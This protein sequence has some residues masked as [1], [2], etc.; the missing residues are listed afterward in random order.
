MDDQIGAEI[1]ATMRLETWHSVN[2]QYRPSGVARR[3][4]ARFETEFGLRH[5]LLTGSGSQAIVAALRGVVPKPS[6]VVAVP[7]GVWEGC[8]R[9]IEWAGFDP[10]SFDVDDQGQPVDR[11]EGVRAVLA[12][13]NLASLVDIGALR[14]AF[15]GA[16]IV[17]DLAHCLGTRRASGHL[18][19]CHGDAAIASFQATKTLSALS[20]GA[21][22]FR[23]ELSFK[24][25]RE[26]I[27]SGQR[28]GNGL[29]EAGCSFLSVA[30]MALLDAQMQRFNEAR[31][32]CA[33]NVARFAAALD[34]NRAWIRADPD[35]LRC[36]TFYSLPIRIRA[37]AEGHTTPDEV[38]SLI[39][40]RTGLVCDRVYEPITKVRSGDGSGHYPH[41]EKRY[42]DE[43][44]IP[45]QAFQAKN[46]E[47]DLLANVIGACDEDY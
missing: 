10:C 11:K 28:C 2:P 43:I 14:V 16:L 18:V 21:A 35:C 37:V 38:I 4:L 17:E 34:P 31:R 45:H 36:G 46:E 20:G 29:A 44:L 39:A 47:I 25:G 7:A 40:L 13:H 3:I 12:V 5:G 33:D 15:P 26:A 6:G 8:L 22:F 19:G 41:A 30:D 32:R 27:F 1:M 9:A 42:S 24:A 23:T